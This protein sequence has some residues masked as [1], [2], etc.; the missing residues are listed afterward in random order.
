MLPAFLK[1]RGLVQQH[2]HSFNYLVEHEI[3]KII[4]ANEKIT[5][6]ADANFY[7]KYGFLRY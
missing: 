4:K 7:L 6:E 1:T 5:V 3:G 2:I